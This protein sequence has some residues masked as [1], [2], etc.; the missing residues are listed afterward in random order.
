M[1][2]PLLAQVVLMFVSVV[3][4]FLLV[5]QLRTQQ[6]IVQDLHNLP[7]DE[8]VH[9]ISTTADD[10]L[11]TRQEI[12]TLHDQIESFRRDQAR[13]K[14]AIAQLAGELSRLRAVTGGAQIEGEG[15]SITVFYDLR[16]ADLMALL[17]EVRNAGGEA[18]A[19]NG[20]RIVARSPISEAEGRLFVNGV[21]M[22]KPFR[23]EVIGD[24][25]TLTGALTRI[26]G[27]LRIWRD[28]AGV[29]SEV[30]P[31]DHLV[32]PR[33]TGPAGFQFAEPVP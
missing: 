16:A 19:L 13:G 9:L 25:D 17:N 3:V 15:V 12:A 21:P 23:L 31:A 26:G 7:T 30:K 20:Q 1:R 22:S 27:L 18:L 6:T 2:L 4:G 33:Y 8:L 10:N 32:L 29:I 11:K 14:S 28:L 24:P 5:T